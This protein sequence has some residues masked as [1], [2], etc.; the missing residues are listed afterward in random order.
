CSGSPE[1]GEAFTFTGSRVFLLLQEE[2]CSFTSN[3]GP[4][5]QLVSLT[6]RGGKGGRK[7][8]MGTQFGEQR[9]ENSRFFTAISSVP[10]KN[11]RDQNATLCP[12][13]GPHLAAQR[14]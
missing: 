12:A 7:L 2:K 11:Y 9:T 6:A 14:Q 4:P 10:T 5:T 1:T 3:A 8:R 13:N